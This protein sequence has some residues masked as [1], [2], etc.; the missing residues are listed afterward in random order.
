MT[1][2]ISRAC[3]SLSVKRPVLDLAMIQKAVESLELTVGIKRQLSGLSL[4]RRMLQ[5]L[6]VT[7]MAD[8]TPNE[9][10]L[11]VAALKLELREIT[12]YT[13]DGLFVE[14]CA[15]DYLCSVK[16]LAAL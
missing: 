3:G 6:T 11:V 7:G 8:M 10:Q 13:F 15:L 4:L 12:K 16:Q 1:S 14:V 9:I 5:Q 2:L